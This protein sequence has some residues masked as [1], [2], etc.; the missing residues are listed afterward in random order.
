MPG[1]PLLPLA[2]QVLCAHLKID[3]CTLSVEPKNQSFLALH[4]TSSSIPL[5]CTIP[6]MQSHIKQELEGEM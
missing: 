4:P 2:F 3:W 6:I 5:L 1:I